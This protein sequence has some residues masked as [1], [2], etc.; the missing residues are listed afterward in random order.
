G[1]PGQ[2]LAELVLPRD[3]DHVGLVMVRRESPARR[4][5][6]VAVIKDY[7]SIVVLARIALRREGGRPTN[8]HAVFRRK[9]LGRKQPRTPSRS[10]IL[11][12]EVAWHPALH[13]LDDAANCGARGLE[14]IQ[15]ADLCCG[16]VGDVLVK[17]VCAKRRWKICGHR[18]QW[19]THYRLSDVTNTP[20]GQVAVRKI[21]S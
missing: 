7:R 9:Y 20:A 16:F 11:E 3:R 12:L 21:I 17:K 10:L 2:V 18:D 5:G 8:M 19:W 4:A 13:I 15:H 1:V 14:F 6:R